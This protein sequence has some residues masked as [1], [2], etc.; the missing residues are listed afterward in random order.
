VGHHEWYTK[1]STQSLQ[2]STGQ[3][4]RDNSP[5]MASPAGSR[6]VVRRPSLL[7]GE[8]ARFLPLVS[9]TV[10]APCSVDGTPVADDDD[11]A[12]FLLGDGRLGLYEQS[13]AWSRLTQFSHGCL[14]SHLTLRWRQG[15]HAVPTFGRQ[16][17][18]DGQR[19]GIQCISRALGSAFR[20][21]KLWGNGPHRTSPHGFARDSRQV[22]IPR[23]PEPISLG[24]VCACRVRTVPHFTVRVDD[25]TGLF[26]RQAVQLGAV[27]LRHG[28]S[29]CWPW[30]VPLWMFRRRSAMWRAFAVWARS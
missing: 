14:L 3:Y 1:P 2:A 12:A 20:D 19:L 11:E 17:D 9:S 25:T 6:L 4:K 10:V 24:P 18:A 23:A 21:M 5:R 26:G 28:E 8:C 13:C 22:E 7:L 27:V 29:L 30:P 15:Q 16:R